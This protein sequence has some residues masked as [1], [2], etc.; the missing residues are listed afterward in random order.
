MAALDEV[1][2]AFGAATESLEQ[3]RMHG[4]LNCGETFD[5][6]QHT[7]QTLVQQASGRAGGRAGGAMK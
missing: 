4:I 5:H 3:Y 7:L 2:P 1:K 6:L